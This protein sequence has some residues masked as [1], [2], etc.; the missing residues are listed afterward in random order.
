MIVS[1]L[2]IAAKDWVLELRTREIVTTAGFFGVLVV[3]IGALSFSTGGIQPALAAP[4]AIWIAIAFTSI[5][6][7][8]R[9]WQR[10]RE[11]GALVGLLLAPIPRP[12]IFIGK[13]LGILGIVLAIN[14]VIVPTAAV[15]FHIDLWTYGAP[16]ALIVTLGT[17]GVT[18][19]GTLFGAMTVRTRARDL[20]LATVLFPLLS[21]ALL[22][23]VAATRELFLGATLSE[24]SG[25][26]GLL[27]IFDAL[28]V[29][30]GIALFGPL[31][32]G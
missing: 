11:D 30:G 7:L 14:L 17:L 22:S 16:L 26:L 2:S 29:A 6:V 27:G 9:A 8:S 32:D 28:V 12:A 31:M 1:L 21:P 10:E 3:V 13:A 20:V 24:L 25:Y 19:C 5:L 4:G 23:G 18:A 15:F